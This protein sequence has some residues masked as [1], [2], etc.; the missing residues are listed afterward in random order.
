[1][2]AVTEA[3]ETL[4]NFVSAF[5]AA[6]QAAPAEPGWMQSIRRG[7]IERFASLGLP[8]ARHEEWR[9]TSVAPIARTLFRL[10]EPGEGVARAG[11]GML[12]ELSFDSSTCHT[13]VFVNGRHVPALSA[14]SELP[15]GVRLGSL[16]T[17]LQNTAASG[18]RGRGADVEELFCI[19]DFNDDAFRA[20][21]TAFMQDG[22]LL[23]FP[24]GVSID[25]PIHVLFATLPDPDRPVPLMTHPRN[26][27]VA[28]A[29]SRVTI[30]ESYVGDMT[31]SCL[32]N[33]VTEI[34]VGRNASV[35]HHKLQREAET[36]FHVGTTHARVSR[37]GRFASHS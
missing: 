22:A 17:T 21:N 30:V 12:A 26:L 35:E 7:A 28:G 34:A 36:A 20:L 32:T 15:E 27:I 11:A 9:K 19:S 8:T 1:M 25:E 6:V 37:D 24:E 18:S 23:R 5:E 16:A 14:T 4:T 31:I 33:A 2:A 3:R 29:G 10:P 13:I